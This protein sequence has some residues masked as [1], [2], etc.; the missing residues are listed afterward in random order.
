MLTTLVKTAKANGRL[1]VASLLWRA[2]ID[3]ILTRGYAKAYGN[4]A[5]YLLELRAVNSSIAD[6]RGHPSHE[7]Y[8]S[9]LR[10]AHVRKASFW[11]RLNSA[12]APE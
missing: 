7:S 4:A 3:A 8:E 2:L 5:R 10:L 1:L 12:S 9:A 6:S 11:G